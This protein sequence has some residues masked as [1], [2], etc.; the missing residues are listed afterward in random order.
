MN[1]DG[2]NPV[3]LY[4]PAIPGAIALQPRAFADRILFSTNVDLPGS[5]SFDIYSIMPDGSGLTRLTNN[6]IYDGFD[7]SRMNYPA[8]GD[9]PDCPFP[10][11]ANSA[12]ECEIDVTSTA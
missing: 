8:G 6:L 7:E 5:N 2:S 1:E 12:V 10:A 4:D 3:P 9:L 11:V